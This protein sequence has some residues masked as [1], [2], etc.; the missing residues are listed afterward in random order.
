MGNGSAQFLK[1]DIFTSDGANDFRP[2]DKHI[3]FVFDHDSKVGHSRTVNRS[4]G[5]GSID[6]R[7]LR[8]DSGAGHI[9]IKNVG[10]AGQGANTFLNAGTTAF[11]EA[12]NRTTG[13]LG[14]VHYF[15]DFAGK[16]FTQGT[17][18]KSCIM[19]K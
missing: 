11:I 19:G 7:D 10:I 5:T 13:L 8:N 17:A 16:Y 1:T 14:Q 9:A 15:A 6:D 12:D 18:Y 2:G 3:A 4:S